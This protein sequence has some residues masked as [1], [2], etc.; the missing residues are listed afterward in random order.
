M[1]SVLPF[2]LHWPRF[3]QIRPFWSLFVI[4]KLLSNRR[5]GMTLELT[6]QLLPSY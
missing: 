2:V 4:R 5:P 1:E 3:A 6:P